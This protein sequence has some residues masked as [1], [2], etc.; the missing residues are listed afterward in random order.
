MRREGS[1][2]I[3]E[4]VT[5]FD[6]TSASLTIP[7]AVSVVD[8]PVLV[9]GLAINAP[10]NMPLASVPVAT[11]IDPEGP[12]PLAAYGASIDWGDGKSSPG[13]IAFDS[14]TNLFTVYGSH[15]YAAPGI[16]SI[17]ITVDHGNAAP[18]SASSLAAVSSSMTETTLRASSAQ[19]VYG[20]SVT[21]TAAVTGLGIPTGDVTFYSGPVNESDELGIGTLS[22]SGG[23]DLA[24]LTISLNASSSPYAITAVYG[25]DSINESSTSNVLDQTVSPAPLSIIVA[26]QTKVYGQP[27]PTLTVSYA[28]FKNGDSAAS[29]AARPSLSTPATTTS[30]V[31]IYRYYRGRRHRSQL[32]DHIRARQAH[33]KQRRDNDRVG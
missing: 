31:G 18:G 32:C 7:N 30:P 16:D 2:A 29:L 4:S 15:T 11:F 12:D 1:Y 3:T 8:Q 28:G 25:G 10:L 23:A 26:N 24:T 27:I 9:T 22:S 6:G 13:T 21:F 17:T 19:V 20:Q 33:S 14:T 5:D